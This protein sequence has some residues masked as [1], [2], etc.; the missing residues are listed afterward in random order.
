[1]AVSPFE[2]RIFSRFEILYVI[3]LGF[4]LVALIIDAVR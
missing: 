2:G 3:F 1:M 4:I